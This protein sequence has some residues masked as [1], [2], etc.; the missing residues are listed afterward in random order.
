VENAARKLPKNVPTDY[1][2]NHKTEN[3]RDMVAG[4]VQSCTV[5]Y[6]LLQSYNVVGREMFL[7]VR[8]VQSYWEFLTKTLGQWA[9][10]LEISTTERRYK[11]NFGR[12]VLADY[13]WRRQETFY[14]QTRVERQPKLLSS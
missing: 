2:A 9:T 10:E 1:L 7:K 3:Y 8:F 4:L 11:V 5:L 12:S 6:S 13:C 14:R